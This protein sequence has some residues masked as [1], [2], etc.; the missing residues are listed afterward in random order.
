MM[1]QSTQNI[2]TGEPYHN[3]WLFIAGF[4]ALSIAGWLLTHNLRT[5]L[6]IFFLDETGYL[7]RGLNMFPKIPKLWGP[8]YCFWYWLLHFVKTDP[9]DLF[10]LNFGLMSVMLG[11]TSYIFLIRFKVVWP[12]A[13][14]ISLM[15]LIAHFN[16]T[17]F[18]KVSHFVTIMFMAGLVLFYYVKSNLDRYALITFLF[19]M[20]SFARP[21][22][23]LSFMICLGALILWMIR[24]RKEIRFSPLLIILAVVAVLFNIGLG[25]PLGVETR[26][27]NR[28]FVAFAEHFSWNYSKWNDLPGYL[29]LA[30]DQVITPEFG[31][32]KS[33]GAA[34]SHNPSMV[35]RHLF[36]NLGQYIQ[37]LGRTTAM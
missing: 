16:L 7:T 1:N 17:T 12:V 21:E 36:Y 35:F 20:L 5:A 22:F 3:R 4:L 23:Y 32:S 31:D 11:L 29:W 24:K 8:A 14:W 25:V 27:Y 9:V 15:V 28:S 13:I 6:D 33:V 19:L 26:G 18:P 37:E 30:W 34:L 2:K 10:F